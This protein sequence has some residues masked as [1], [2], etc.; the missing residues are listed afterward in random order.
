MRKNLDAK[1]G[2]YFRATLLLIKKA[3]ETQ[4]EGTIEEPACHGSVSA[5]DMP[6]VLIT[7]FKE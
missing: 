3:K 7:F 4:T 1:A 6:Q 5:K 2:K